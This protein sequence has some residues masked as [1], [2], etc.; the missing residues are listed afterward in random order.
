MEL[1]KCIEALKKTLNNISDKI[2]KEVLL[3][4]QSR[5]V[6]KGQK[7]IVV[8]NNSYHIYSSLIIILYLLNISAMISTNNHTLYI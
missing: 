2:I 8:G 3:N 4:F 7:I 1:T 6:K 5:L